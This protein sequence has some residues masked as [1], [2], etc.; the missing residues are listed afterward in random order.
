MTPQFCPYTEKN[1]II[2]TVKDKKCYS[3]NLLIGKCKFLVFSG[4]YAISY[5]V[6][7]MFSALF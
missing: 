5:V 1:I 3:K 7:L 6:K 2:V 4:L